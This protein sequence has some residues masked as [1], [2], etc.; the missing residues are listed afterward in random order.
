MWPFLTTF[1][2]G[3]L[4]GTWL[5]ALPVRPRLWSAEPNPVGRDGCIAMLAVGELTVLAGWVNSLGRSRPH[6]AMISER[7]ALGTGL[8]W[9]SCGAVICIAV[10]RRWPI[11]IRDEDGVFEFGGLI[12]V[13]TL[14]LYALM[15]LLQV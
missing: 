1:V 6:F 7:M 3:M 15:R 8:M 12:V 9:A 5:R 13:G 10:L 14:S 11:S 4:I 2:V